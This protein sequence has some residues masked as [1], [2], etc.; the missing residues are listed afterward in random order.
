MLVTVCT[1]PLRSPHEILVVVSASPDIPNPCSTSPRP[2]PHVT[3]TAFHTSSNRSDP[4]SQLS[5]YVLSRSRDW[6]SP[7]KSGDWAII[8]SV[9]ITDRD[10]VTVGRMVWLH[11]GGTCWVRC[12]QGC[13]SSSLPF[14][15]DLLSQHEV[16]GQAAHRGKSFPGLSMTAAA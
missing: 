13:S 3:E 12:Q 6:V 4:S 1:C 2:L 15:Q 14:Y 5:L 9:K 10:R 11:L 16:Q 7:R 8:I